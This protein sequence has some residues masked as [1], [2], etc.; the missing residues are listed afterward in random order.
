MWQ[1]IQILKSVDTLFI[2]GW[3]FFSSMCMSKLV[4][5]IFPEFQKDSYDQYS[6]I[7]IFAEIVLSLWLILLISRMIRILFVDYFYS[8]LDGIFGYQ[9]RLTKEATGGVIFSF[10]LFLFSNNLKSKIS[11]FGNRIGLIN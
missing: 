11:Y 2:A 3:Y 9:R 4:D 5:K 7:Y 1:Y 8:P 10:C 6:T